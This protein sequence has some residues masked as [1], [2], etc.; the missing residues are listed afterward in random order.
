MITDH[1]LLKIMIN[2]P[3]IESTMPQTPK[4]SGILKKILISMAS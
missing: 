1:F 2:A 3:M 4:N